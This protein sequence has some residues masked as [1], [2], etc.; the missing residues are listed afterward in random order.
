[1][2]T[3]NYW[4]ID[5]LLSPILF[6]PDDDEFI[7]SFDFPDANDENRVKNVFKMQITPRLLKFDKGKQEQIKNTLR[8]YLSSIPHENTKERPYFFRKL[9]STISPAFTF[10]NE[11]RLFF[12]RLWEVLYGNE[13]YQIDD[14]SD[15]IE[16]YDVEVLNQNFIVDDSI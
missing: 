15:Y 6:D 16:D 12:V 10:P 9:F 5:E 11:P 4:Y 13:S 2:K 3:V 14:Y 1:M 7:E 8:F